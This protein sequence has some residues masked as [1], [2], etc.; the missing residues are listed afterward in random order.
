MKT[1]N[2][3]DATGAELDWLVEVALGGDHTYPPRNYS[4]DLYQGSLILQREKIEINYFEKRRTD[5]GTES[6]CRACLQPTFTFQNFTSNMAAKI[7]ADG[8]D[9]LIAGM[10]CFVIF[11]LGQTVQV[12]CDLATD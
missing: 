10:R 9:L 5:G 6:V 7:T 12:P 3:A 1:I 2:C 4:T 8:S 11:K